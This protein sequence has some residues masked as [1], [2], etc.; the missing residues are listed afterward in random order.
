MNSIARMRSGGLCDK[1]V[2]SFSGFVISQPAL[3]ED[4]DVSRRICFSALL[5]LYMMS[6]DGEPAM[7]EEVCK[8]TVARMRCEYLESPLG[9]DVREP[10]LSWIVKSDR[11]AQHQTTYQILVAGDEQT[12]SEDRGDL[13]DTGRV[14]SDETLQIPYAG[15][16]LSSR[17]RCFWKVRVWDGEGNASP[18]SPVAFWTM[19][20]LEPSDWQAKWIGQSP[21]EFPEDTEPPSPLIRKNFHVSGK[22]VRATAWV[23][24]QGYYE[25]HLNGKAIGDAVCSPHVSDYAKRAY[26]VTHDITDAIQSGDNCAGVWLGRG[27][28]AEGF[29]GVVHRG[30]IMRVQIEVEMEDGSLLRIGSDEGWRTCPGP[31]TTLGGWKFGNL[32]GERYDQRAEV[33]GW[34]VSGFDDSKWTPAEVSTPPTETLSALIMPPNRVT[35][36]I[37]PASVEKLASGEWFFDFGRNLTGVI[38]MRLTGRAGEPIEMAFIERK[39]EDGDWIDYGQRDEFIP[40]SEKTGTFR[41]RFNYHAFRYLAVKGL[42]APPTKEDVNALFVRVDYELRGSFECSNELLNKIYET[43]M[44]TY[45]CVSAG[46]D[47]VDCPHRERLGYGGD[48][49]ITSRTA[50]YAY[51]LGSLY[52][53]WLG[54]W[55]D[56]QNSDT[57]EIPNTAPYPYP[58]GGGPTWGAISVFLPWDLYLHYGDKRVLRDCYPMMKAYVRFLDSKSD[59]NQLKPYGHKD[60]GFL[61]DWVAPGYDQGYGPW[62]PEEWRTFFNNCFYFHIVQ[63]VSKTASLLEEGAD[64]AKYAQQAEAIRKATHERY[65]KPDEGIY[66]NGGQAYLAFPLQVGLPPDDVR[67]VLIKNLEKAIVDKAKGHIDAGMHG[68]MFVLRCLNELRR[69]DLAF[70]MVNQRSYPGWGY[71]IDQGAT[72]LWERWDGEMSQIHSTL[73]AAGEWFPRAL[74]GIKPDENQPGFKRVIIDPRPVGDLTWAKT[75]YD[76]IRGPAITSWRLQDGR[77]FLDVQ[78]AAN[79]TGLVRLPAREES[80]VRVTAGE[81]ARLLKCEV[82]LAEFEIGSGRYSFESSEK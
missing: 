59:N 33:A 25:L 57:G 41:N 14:D 65:F 56:A 38:E 62:S 10:R 17:A 30:P 69:D 67:S 54:N 48:S 21:D 40:A 53:K 66:V 70:L 37:Q 51:D 9:I 64:A 36:T 49:Q 15:K 28:Y 43:T 73:L 78:L 52:T 12:L 3:R 50:L 2:S 55:R 6:P 29:P 27:W 68:S 8:L 75:S 47:T 13:W 63:Q 58:A 11:N 16:P 19:G 7:G 18:W 42:Q 20:L 34:D 60:Y 31:I 74:G 4:L 23:A 22:P 24:A 72:T 71:M 1:M 76:T 35:E 61:G 44:Y 77:F 82:G 5:F 32:G 81:G 45:R 39:D 46:G 26:Y 79:M 80:S